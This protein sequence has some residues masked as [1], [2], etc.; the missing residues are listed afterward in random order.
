MTGEF[1]LQTADMSVKI[2]EFGTSNSKLRSIFVSN[3]LLLGN[4]YIYRRFSRSMQLGGL[5]SVLDWRSLQGVRQSKL[6]LHA[7]S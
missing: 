6:Y 7:N 3:Y 5:G 2:T 4:K 1:F